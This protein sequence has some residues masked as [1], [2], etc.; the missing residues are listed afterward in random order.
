MC[1]SWLVLIIALSVVVCLWNSQQTETS[2]SCPAECICLS[3]TQV[4][5]T[6]YLYSQG[7]VPGITGGGTVF[8]GL[9]RG[10]NAAQWSWLRGTKDYS[11]YIYNSF[12]ENYLTG[13]LVEIG[14]KITLGSLWS[15]DGA[16]WKCCRRKSYGCR[17]KHFWELAKY[18]LKLKKSPRNLLLRIHISLFIFFLWNTKISSLDINYLELFIFFIEVHTWICYR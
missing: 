15:Q 10:G 13:I 17:N 6:I 11:I 3:Q 1:N 9:W 5:L 18:I 14:M 2:K 8:G 12:S 7:Q 4:S 16:G